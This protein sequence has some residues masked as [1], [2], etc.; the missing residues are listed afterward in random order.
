MASDLSS[1]LAG[2]FSVLEKMFNSYDA[3]RCGT[4]SF[5][6][7][8]RRLASAGFRDDE[9]LSKLFSRVDKD[10]SGTLD[11]SEFIVLMYLWAEVGSYAQLIK[12]QRYA[13]TVKS[14]FDVMERCYT[15]YDADKSRQLSHDEFQAFMLAQLPNAYAQNQAVIQEIFPGSLPVLSFSRFL[16]LLYR[17]VLPNGAFAVRPPVA[18]AG[19]GG[20]TLWAKL[21]QCFS[22]ME[23]DFR[24]FDEDRSNCIDLVELTQGVSVQRPSSERLDVLVRMEYYFRMVDVD[25]SETIDFFE[26]MYLA[27]LITQNGSY[28]DL[29]DKAANPGAVKECFTTLRSAYKKYDADGSNRLTIDEVQ[30]FMQGEFGTVPSSMDGVFH[31]LKSSVERPHIDFVRFMHLLYEVISPQGAYVSAQ[32]T[33]PSAPQARPLI[34]AAAGQGRA[35]APRFDSINVQDIRK[36][37]VLGQGGQGIVYQAEYQGYVVGA[38]FLL[39]DATQE[40]CDETQEECALM[41]RM[42]HVNVHMLLGART[43]MPDICMLTE[44]CSNGSLFDCY[45]KRRMNFDRGTRWRFARECAVGINVLHSMQPVIMHRDIKSL[46]VFLDDSFTVKV[47]DFGMAK[48]PRDG[49]VNLQG[50]GTPQWCAPEVLSSTTYNERADVFSYGVLLWEIMHLQCPYV[51]TGMDQAQIARAVCHRDIRP[52]MSSS[53]PPA[54]AQLIAR[55]WHRDPAQRPRLTDVISMLDL[56]RGDFC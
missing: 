47:A 21:Q 43:T 5:K 55:C 38:K 2:A 40:L 36:G 13:D 27:F 7:L 52:R 26:F 25:G 53:L 29:V 51:D 6:Q 12:D 18:S 24:Q 39:A 1:L 44:F 54:M 20:P 19:G 42:D 30:A 23:V 22:N 34:S 50:M 48:D 17:L 45:M 8:V 32:P 3:D 33:K 37:K 9:T 16:H 4:I 28:R 41:R 11:F 35:K 15:S 46:N 49:R 10:K 14:A 31:K 56:M